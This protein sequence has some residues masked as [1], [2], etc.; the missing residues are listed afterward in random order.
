MR[1]FCS[2][3]SVLRWICV[4]L[5]RKLQVVLG[6]FLPVGVVRGEVLVVV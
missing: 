4:W 3:Q 5:M 2:L 6:E 1:G